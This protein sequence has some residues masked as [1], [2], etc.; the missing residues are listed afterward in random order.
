M[1]R[2]HPCRMPPLCKG[3]WGA[4]PEGLARLPDVPFTGNVLR[5]HN[6]SVAFGASSPCTGEPFPY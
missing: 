1:G 6:P 5:V 4:A 2:G 3:R